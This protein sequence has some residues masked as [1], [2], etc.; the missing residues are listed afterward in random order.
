MATEQNR[1]MYES[2]KRLWLAE[3]DHDDRDAADIEFDRFFADLMRQGAQMVAEEKQAEEVSA[4][5]MLMEII[6]EVDTS[7]QMVPP[8]VKK[9]RDLLAKEGLDRTSTMEDGEGGQKGLAGINLADQA[10]LEFHRALL[11]LAISIAQ[12]EAQERLAKDNT[13][14]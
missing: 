14:P 7:M 1:R 11:H 6:L 12:A 13:Q 9:Y 4:S 2:L 8:R 10:A 3:H 5:R